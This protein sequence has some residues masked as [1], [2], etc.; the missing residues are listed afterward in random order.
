MAD[1]KNQNDA[2]QDL[3]A[4]LRSQMSQLDEKFGTAVSDTPVENGSSSPAEASEPEETPEVSAEEAAVTAFLAEELPSQEDLSSQ[5]E[6][7]IEEPAED[8]AE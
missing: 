4:R 3:L 5:E 1:E 6:E 8:I 7:T 2:V